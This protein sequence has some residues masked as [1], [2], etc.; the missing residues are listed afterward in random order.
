LF[1]LNSR[2]WN[3][4]PSVFTHASVKI[5]DFT[6]SRMNS[7]RRPASPPAAD[8]VHDAHLGRHPV[9]RPDLELLDDGESAF[10]SIASIAS[11]KSVT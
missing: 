4:T 5:W 6:M 11:A 8:S 3:S 1:A 7:R 2:S 9:D 10:A